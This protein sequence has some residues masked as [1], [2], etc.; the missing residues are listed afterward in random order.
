MKISYS[1]KNGKTG[2]MRFEMNAKE[3]TKE[4]I[5]RQCCAGKITAQDAAKR[6]RLSVRQVENLK[7][8]SREGISL[9]HGNCGRV[10][11]KA[12]ST[13]LCRRVLD[14]YHKVEALKMNFTHFHEMLVSKKIKI[15][16]TAMRNML[17][18]EGFRSPK[19]RRKAKKIHKSRERREKFGELLQMDATP[20]EW[21]GGNKKFAL[22]GSIDDARGQVTGLHMSENECTDGY[23]EIMRQTL[24]R[25]GTP[26]AFYVDGLSI[27]FSHCKSEELTIE[28]QLSGVF[29]RKTQFGLICDELGIELIHAHSSQ[30]KGRIER[31]WQTL[32]SRLPVEFAL[33]GITTKEAANKFL[34]EEYIDTFNSLFAV[35]QESKSCFV[36]LPKNVDLDRILSYKITRKLD[37]GGCFSWNNVRFLVIGDIANC[38]VQILV[39][40]RIGVQVLFEDKLFQIKPLSKGK[41]SIT[42]TDS[43]DAILSRF[44]FFSCLK[45]EHV[46]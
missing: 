30:A 38:K 14:E 41:E 32:Q 8:K 39:S 6:L 20:F 37:S 13:E 22:H 21:F 23:L 25:Y 44:V 11:K 27:F 10:S 12:L 16:Y 1:K 40:N 17:I 9:L 24:L 33:R 45:N 7:K 42:T 4:G 18:R 35:N 19:K 36:R 3:R 2:G 31:L 26:E 15:S 28:E 29:E 46:A 34:K 5:I 43:V